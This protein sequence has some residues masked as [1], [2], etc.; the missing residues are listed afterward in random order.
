MKLIQGILFPVFI[1]AYSNA[2]FSQTE[3]HSGLL[4]AQSQTEELNALK[5]HSNEALTHENIDIISKEFAKYTESIISFHFDVANS[6][7]YVKYNSSI[8]L[9]FVMGILRRVSIDTYYLNNGVEVH[10]VKNPSDNFKF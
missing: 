9:N 7:I 10:Y 6:K 5:L 4:I 1:L 8:E 3:I 2:S